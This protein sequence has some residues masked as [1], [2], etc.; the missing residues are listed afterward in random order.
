MTSR[1]ACWLLS[2]TLVVSTA[3]ATAAPQAN[4]PPDGLYRFDLTGTTT[5]PNGIST[6]Q[7]TDG[8]TGAV[9]VTQTGVPPRHYPGQGPVT[10]CIKSGVLPPL[11]RGVCVSVG[12][13]GHVPIDCPGLAGALDWQ[14]ID[15]KT[16][17]A[18]LDLTQDW[19]VTGGSPTAAIDLMMPGL[20]AADKQ[21]A[22][23]LKQQLPAMQQQRE[24]AMT[25]A[26]AQMEAELRTAS[27]E[28]A[29][30]IRQALAAMQGGT[31]ASQVRHVAVQ[32]L[33]RIADRCS[34]P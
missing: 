20:S 30:M 24:Q 17:E 16:W 5:L 12:K 18:R 4:V 33:T 27:P 22:Q 21:K 10:R 8:R 31:P 11:P 15:D 7:A 23:A 29:A 25:Q 34:P 3:T 19:A 13:D 2:A 32:R 28:D 14:P 6:T 9:T 1:I 26:R